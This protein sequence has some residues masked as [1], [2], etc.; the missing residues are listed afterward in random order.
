MSLFRDTE[1]SPQDAQDLV[2]AVHRYSIQEL[3]RI[4]RAERDRMLANLILKAFG[5][6]STLVKGVV[7]ASRA[8]LKAE[9]LA[10]RTRRNISS[11]SL[12]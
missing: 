6:V 7:R 3:E 2:A 8:Q 1:P 9:A 11:R 5:A 12:G 10:Y 4:A